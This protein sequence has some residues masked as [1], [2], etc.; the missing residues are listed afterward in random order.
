[1]NVDIILIYLVQLN[2]KLLELNLEREPNKNTDSSSF[3][4][5]ME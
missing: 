5:Y 1:M 2:K 4:N 3:S